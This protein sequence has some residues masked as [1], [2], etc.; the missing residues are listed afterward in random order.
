MSDP[1]LTTSKHSIEHP[2]LGALLAS[3]AAAARVAGVFAEVRLEGSMLH[4]TAP[5]SAAPAEFRVFADAGKVWVALT[6]ADRWLSQSIEAD[7]VHTGDKMDEL[8]E[9]ELVDLDWKKSWGPTRLPFEHFRDDHKLYTFRSP[10][11]AT[12]PEGVNRV[13]I[14]L[15]AYERAFRV[16]G[17]MEAD[18]EE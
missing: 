6:T 13:A 5:A 3:V 10:V 15:L 8:V 4:C 11:D 16:L 12:G 14:A 2:G 9:E 17:D 1:G 18:D 7:L